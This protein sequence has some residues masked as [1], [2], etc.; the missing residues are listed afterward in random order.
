[1]RGSSHSMWV[2]LMGLIVPFPTDAN[3]QINQ[4]YQILVPAQYGKW[5]D[6][7]QDATT[8]AHEVFQN[9]TQVHEAD[10]KCF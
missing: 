3:S 1:M 9:L 8:I 4:K 5:N 7:L 10:V 6:V 2:Q